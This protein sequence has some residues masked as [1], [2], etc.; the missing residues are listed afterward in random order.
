MDVLLMRH[1]YDDH[2]YI[3]GLNDTSLTADGIEIVRSASERY[4][5]ELGVSCET[6]VAL[7]T[8]SKRRAIETAEIMSEELHRHRI[9]HTA[10]IDPSLRELCQGDM[11]G[12]EGKRHA[13]RVRMLELGWEIFERE[14]TN[15]NDD[16]R[17]GAPDLSSRRYREF[18]T[19]IA[20]PYGESQNELSARVETG[21]VDSIAHAL[22]SEQT[23]LFIAHRGTIREILNIV[24]AHNG[25]R[26][27]VKQNEHIEMAGW[28]YCEM[29]KT[30]LNDANFSLGA[31]TRGVRGRQS[32]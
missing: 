21:F 26:Y 5:K 22:S 2:G 32:F 31:L 11:V 23:P 9:E 10:S 7:R 25:G 29:F 16:Y 19:F 8:S 4:A 3:D 14:R 6:G 30:T 18:N 13:E 17:Y 20:P 15:G 24:I 12:L 1:G 28:K 27:D